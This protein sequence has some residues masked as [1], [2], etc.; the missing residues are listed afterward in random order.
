MDYQYEKGEGHFEEDEAEEVTTNNPITEK[1][2][3]DTILTLDNYFTPCNGC[4]T[5]SKIKDYLKCPAYFK[6]KHI[7]GE[8]KDK[9]KAAYLIGGVVDDL[10][11]MLDTKDRNKYVVVSRRNLKN[12]PDGYVEV[13][14]SQYD[15]II[16]IAD[17]VDRTTAYNELRETGTFQQILEF[18]MDLGAHFNRLAGIPDHIII[19]GNTCI[20]T[21]L[22]TSQT[23]DPKRYLYSCLEYGY[24]GQQAVYQ[25]LVSLLYPEV[26]KYVSRHLVVEK[27]PNIYNV[28]TFIL[29]QDRIEHAKEVMLDTIDIIKNDSTFAKKDA[30]WKDATTIGELVEMF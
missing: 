13:L 2:K 10:L 21:D 24:F 28:A 26:T 6:G 20:I 27:T 1:V 7:T 12:P 19:D 8:V 29:D 23:I 22:K 14:D 16:G 15:E 30:T 4:L 11:T 18:P 17:A 9:Q 25:Y 3:V 5:N